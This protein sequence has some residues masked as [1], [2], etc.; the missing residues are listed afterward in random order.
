[1]QSRCTLLRLGRTPYQQAW[2]LQERIA[3]DVGAGADPVLILLEHPPTYTLGSRGHAEHLL[4]SDEAYH[5]RGAE[6]VRTDR[7]GDVT[8]HGPGQLV[9]YPIL[10]LRVLGLGPV[11]YVQALESLLIDAL[12]GFG[13]AAGRSERNRGVWVDDAKIAAIGVH[14]S[15]GIAT[16]GFA[17][18]VNTDLSR[19]GDIVPCGLTDA[20]V[21]SMQHLTGT[22]FAMQHVEDA[23][24][25]SFS[26]TFGVGL[27]PAD[28]YEVGAL[29]G[30]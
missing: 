15:R 24:A 20:S 29:I 22:T 11:R 25:R 1:L 3:A 19:F 12:A 18:N 5:A 17:L 7:G 14:I 4:L 26:R 2:Q 16:H 21:T 23:V 6:V 13:I 28:T 10:D 8:Y 9:G 27:I 30:S